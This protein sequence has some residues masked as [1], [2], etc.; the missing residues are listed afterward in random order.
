MCAKVRIKKDLNLFN[1]MLYNIK[2]H[3]YEVLFV[4]PSG[5]KNNFIQFH[6]YSYNRCFIAF[7]ENDF[8]FK[9]K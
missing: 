3:S 9:M 6:I 1:F 4:P 5:I 2:K 8:S 7:Q